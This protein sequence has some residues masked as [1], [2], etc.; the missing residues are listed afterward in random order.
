MFED[1]TYEQRFT[2]TS[3]HIEDTTD[4]TLLAFGESIADELAVPVH[5]LII[6]LPP[7]N[8]VE[9]NEG[10]ERVN[11]EFN[12]QGNDTAVK[13][14][15][16]APGEMRITFSGLHAGRISLAPELEIFEDVLPDPDDER[17]AEV[18]RYDDVSLS[19]IVVEFDP[20]HDAQLSACLMR[21]AHLCEVVVGK[22]APRPDVDAYVRAVE[23]AEVTIY[24]DADVVDGFCYGEPWARSLA[25]ASYA[26][27]LEVIRDHYA[28]TLSVPAGIDLHWYVMPDQRRAGPFVDVH[29]HAHGER[30]EA[31]KNAVEAALEQASE[32]LRFGAG[33]A[34]LRASLGATAVSLR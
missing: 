24:L 14:I 16:L 18:E 21:C 1:E 33:A 32:E 6:T 29:R 22:L 30:P 25:P 5:A 17:F 28:S 12:E 4:Y 20:A 27:L 19:S 9:R 34:G 26:R 2:A 11:V 10:S 8:P 7:A 23:P 13:R 31:I 15:Q 3:V